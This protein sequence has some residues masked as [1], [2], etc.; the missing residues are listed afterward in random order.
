ML[1]PSLNLNEKQNNQMYKEF[2][3]QLYKYRETAA[4][5][6]CRNMDFEHLK[7]WPSGMWLSCL[8]G[9]WRL[10]HQVSVDRDEVFANKK[11]NKIK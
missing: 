4:K 10:P 6:L 3:F 2:E 11:I 1:S 5:E 8:G 9:W 7:E